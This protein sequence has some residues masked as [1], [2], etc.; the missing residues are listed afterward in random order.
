MVTKC[1]LA[2]DGIRVH[3]VTWKIIR[4]WQTKLEDVGQCEKKE[5][6]GE[7]L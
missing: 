5:T 6:E 7:S 3:T 2:G 4:E 1:L